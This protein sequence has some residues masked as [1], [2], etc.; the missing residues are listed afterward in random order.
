LAQLHIKNKS[1]EIHE[2]PEAGDRCLL[3]L[4]ISKLPP[5]AVE[6][7]LFYVRPMKTVNKQPPTYGRSV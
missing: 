3:D 4:Y 6:K 2:N 5:E 7:D 1:V